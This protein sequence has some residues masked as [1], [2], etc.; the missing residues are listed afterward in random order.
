MLILQ[1]QT[2][3][4]MKK[5]RA[6]YLAKE[7]QINKRLKEFEAV[8]RSSEERIFAEMSFCILTPQSKAVIADRCIEEMSRNSVLYRGS[9]LQIRK[10]L[11]GVRFPNN[12][13]AYIVKTRK[14]FSRNGKLRL[15]E[16]LRDEDSL[17]LRDNFVKRVSGY[18]FKE[19]S[20]FLRNIG[21]GSDIAILDRHIMKELLKFG[22][23]DKVP[24]NLSRKKYLIIEKR[25]RE[26][27][28]KVG[29]PMDG[30]D[31]LFWYRATGYF[32]K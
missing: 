9:E 31:L 12:K 11:K 28:K 15:R 26:F 30:L 7:S 14:E 17:I 2:A 5:L 27:S 13:A 21:L 3:P 24:E 23:I 4:E 19:A 8:G 10:Y 6:L 25:M 1:L 18:G 20:H 32:F 22:V 16:F 29:I